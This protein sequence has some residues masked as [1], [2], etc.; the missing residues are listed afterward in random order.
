M[1][2]RNPKLR[3][4]GGVWKNK[5]REVMGMAEQF[6]TPN[7]QQRSPGADWPRTPRSE[8]PRMEKIYP[9]VPLDKA[10]RDLSLFLFKT[11]FPLVEGRSGKKHKKMQN[12]ASW[13]DSS[14]NEY[15]GKIW[16]D[17]H[18]NLKYDAKIL[19][20]IL[21]TEGEN[22]V[23]YMK[24][25]RKKGFKERL[26][27]FMARQVVDFEKI[28]GM[29]ELKI[30]GI[31]GNFKRR[32]AA[33]QYGESFK[34]MAVPVSAA[35]GA[36][37]TGIL[38]APAWAIIG[39]AAVAGIVTWLGGQLSLFSESRIEKKRYQRLMKVTAELDEI[40]KGTERLFG[41]YY[42]MLASE[43]GYRLPAGCAAG[44]KEDAEKIVAQVKGTYGFA[45]WFPQIGV[46]VPDAPVGRISAA[47]ESERVI[48]HPESER[49]RPVYRHNFFP[50]VEDNKQAC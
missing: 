46:E 34:K 17:W 5:Q 45:L 37:I 18:E 41:I 13:T 42:R 50:Y 40:Q 32:M 8:W 39:T 14:M 15:I 16:A 31:E 38:G 1:P 44:T 43:N 2:A 21:A 3:D 25:D 28:C 35:A 33:P 48:V 20:E 24:V 12:G 6:A 29:I 7:S 10:A 23:H 26:L 22:S 11:R 19:A 9:P 4:I 49:E 47:P 27:Q 36:A 30:D